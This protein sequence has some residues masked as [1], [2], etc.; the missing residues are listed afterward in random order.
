MHATDSEDADAR[1]QQ[2]AKEAKPPMA[3]S[4]SSYLGLNN[5]AVSPRNTSK[6]MFMSGKAFKYTLLAPEKHA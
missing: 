5:D 6:C 4:P 3:A 1:L 2:I